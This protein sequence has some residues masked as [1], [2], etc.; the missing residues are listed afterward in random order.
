MKILDRMTEKNQKFNGFIRHGC[1]FSHEFTQNHS[2]SLYL[3]SPFFQ[4]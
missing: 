2:Q 3:V 4:P 1:S